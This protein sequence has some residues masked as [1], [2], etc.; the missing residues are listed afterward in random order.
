M[1]QEERGIEMEAVYT[2]DEKGTRVDVHR[3]SA[4]NPGDY[5]YVGVLEQRKHKVTGGPGGTCHHC[6]K[7]IRWSVKFKHLPSNNVVVF[8]YQCTDIL[9]LSDNR[10]DHE[11][12]LLKR[13]AER[14]RKEE[15]WKQATVDRYDAFVAE[16]PELVKFLDEFDEDNS[17]INRVK[18]GIEKY[19]SPLPYQIDSLKRFIAGREKFIAQRLA[20]TKALESAPVLVEG[21]QTLV[22]TVKST[23]MQHSDYG[24]TRKMTVVLDNGN[25]VYGT[26]PSDLYLAVDVD[27]MP[28]TRVSFDASVKPQEDHFGYFSRPTKTKVL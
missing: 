1:S 4:I 24:D 25:K 15:G 28:G 8:G 14:E 17:Y 22:G 20:E 21:R 2:H 11:M 6:G 5:E 12:V 23:K 13:R 9:T 16:Y 7:A 3:P 10:I 19:G 18:W 26:V 27:D